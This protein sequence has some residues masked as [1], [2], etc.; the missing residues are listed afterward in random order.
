MMSCGINKHVGC[1]KLM[2]ANCHLHG[3][4]STG[5]KKCCELVVSG[6]C[7]NRTTFD[8]LISLDPLVS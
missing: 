1:P 2:D 3:V 4:M 7:F 6:C 8:P 5:M